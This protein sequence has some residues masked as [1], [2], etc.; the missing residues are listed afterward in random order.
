MTLLEHALDLASKGFYVFP[1]NPNSKRPAI[2][3]YRNKATREPLQIKSWWARQPTFNIGI[4]TDRYQDDE[5]LIVIDV[6]NKDGRSGDDIIFEQELNGRE[7]PKTFTQYTPSGGRHIFYRVKESITQGS[8][9]FGKRGVDTR[10]YG[11]YVVGRGSVIDG[12]AYTNHTSP[13]EQAP[14]WLATFSRKPRD[15]SE[16]RV[17][18]GV[19]KQYAIERAVQYL[20]TLPEVL[21]GER[22][23]KGYKTACVVKDL[24]V[25]RLDCAMLMLEY[26]KCNP[27][28][29]TEELTAVIDSAYEHGTEPQGS[30]SPEADF[31]TIEQNEKELTP[32]EKLNKEYAFVI[33]GG[34]SHIL[35][36]TTDASNRF[37]LQHLNLKTFHDKHASHVLYDANN[38]KTQITQMWMRAPNRRSFDGICFMPGLEAPERFY[39]LWRG[40][41]VEPTKGAPSPQAKE[42]VDMFIEHVTVNVCNSNQKLARW[43]IG[44][45]AHMIQKP[46][47]KPLVALVFRGGKGV[48]KS[49][50]IE[51]VGHLLGNHFMSTS[52]RR[53]LVG[54]FNG[55]LEDLLLFTLEEAFW[56]GDKQ[57][58]GLL[59]NLITGQKHI[60]EHKGEKPYSVDNRT[61]IVIIGNEEWIVPA[62]HDERRFAVFD[63]GDGKKQNRE[64]FHKMKRQM[65]SGGYSYLL[66]YL[67]EFDLTGL[68]VNEAPKT[69]GL[70]DQ[71]VSSLDPLYQFWL[72]CLIQG[73]IVATGFEESWITTIDKGLFR[74]A[75]GKYLKERQIRSWVPDEVAF[76]KAIKKICPS[77]VPTKRREGERTINT[78]KLPD[79]DGARKDFD[80]FIGEDSV[81]D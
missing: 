41:S 45:F 6:D 67:L 63:V 28:L 8:A 11:G 13:V 19:D 16:L 48:G 17:I 43:L 44:Y 2:T 80:V 33:A 24:G 20:K 51:R 68:D 7:F 22:N 40:F 73:R 15:K 29:E 3:D 66:K 72:D 38:K 47:E 4:S 9:V 69:K 18:E 77:V 14:A 49:S 34:G 25:D 21:E 62:S 27:A 10:S 79:L 81:W 65:E 50:M 52:D 37:D 53:Y 23:D 55:H 36:E 64:Y 46:Y 35:W 54:N 26:W 76:T 57:A 30:S 12:K 5:A 59:K 70:H 32:V 78:Y 61:R 39:N 71:K 75:Y 74:Q 42:S 58:E 60:I 31:G 1:L 56:S